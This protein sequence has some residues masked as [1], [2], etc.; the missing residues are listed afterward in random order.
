MVTKQELDVVLTDI[1]RVFKNLDKQIE[2]LKQMYVEL[3]TECRKS[4][5]TTKKGK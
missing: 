5:S 4:K 3:R 2:G 1:N